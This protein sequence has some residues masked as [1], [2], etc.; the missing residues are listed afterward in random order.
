MQS[1]AVHESLFIR[2]DPTAL[3]ALAHKVGALM[4]AKDKN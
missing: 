3:S 4:K 1:L 2:A